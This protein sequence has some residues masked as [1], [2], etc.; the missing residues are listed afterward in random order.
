MKK[1][2]HQPH[3][4]D[5]SAPRDAGRPNA[6]LSL[7]SW[8][9]EIIRLTLLLLLRRVSRKQ[10]D[11]RR[12]KQKL[13]R[14]F[15]RALD[16]IPDWVGDEAGGLDS[17]DDIAGEVLTRWSLLPQFTR[18]GLPRPLPEKGRVSLTSLIRS[19]SETANPPEVIASLA[20]T[21]SIDLEGGLYSQTLRH[22]ELRHQPHLQRWHHVR[23]VLR[24][25]RTVEGNARRQEVLR[26]FEFM[27]VGQV[28]RQAYSALKEQIGEQ[29]HGFLETVDDTV[30]SSN[31]SAP[32]ASTMEFGVAVIQCDERPLP[33]LQEPSVPNRTGAPK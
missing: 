20:R 19:I 13:L 29:A 30:L 6:E 12:Y 14:Y 8:T 16:S 21:K 23:L 1:K 9:K 24:V 7:D 31:R 27:S 3:Q 32:N 25:L 17:C 18:D 15:K 5:S 33:P 22:M 10:W 11:L 28:P 2:Q 4:D 26:R